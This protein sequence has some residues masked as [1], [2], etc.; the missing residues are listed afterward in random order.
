MESGQIVKL[1]VYDGEASLVIVHKT[2]THVNVC[3][4]EEYEAAK[5]ENREPVLVGFPLTD[6]IEET[7]ELA[8]G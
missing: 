3:T 6:I 1:R 8:T 5:R 2:D 4:P 7:K